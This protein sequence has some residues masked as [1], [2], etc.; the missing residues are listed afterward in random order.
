ML[1]G[2]AVDANA[3]TATAEIA[4]QVVDPPDDIHGTARYRRALLAT[5]VE[6]ALTSASSQN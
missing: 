3:I 6:R 4:A 1:D 2:R 5:L